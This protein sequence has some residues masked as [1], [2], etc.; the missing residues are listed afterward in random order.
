MAI[1][2]SNPTDMNITTCHAATIAN[3]A[4]AELDNNET[5]YANRID[6]KP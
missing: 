2:K 5:Q 6:V 1:W 3:A 4:N